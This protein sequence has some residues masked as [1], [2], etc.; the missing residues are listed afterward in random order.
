MVEIATVLMPCQLKDFFSSK[1][2]LSAMSHAMETTTTCAA[3]NF[4]LP[5]TLQVCCLEGYGKIYV[6]YTSVVPNQGA[7]NFKNYFIFIPMKQAKGAA[8]Y[9][10]N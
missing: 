7:A 1:R 6:V 9:L 4:Q 2:K 8:K 5:Y 10:H 3:D